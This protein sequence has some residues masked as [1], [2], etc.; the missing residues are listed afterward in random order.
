VTS[1]LLGPGDE[2]TWEA[3]HFGVR[4][5]LTARITRFEPP[6]LFEDEMVRGAFRSFTHTHEFRPVEGG[7]LMVDTF[8]YASPLGPLGVLA[9]KLFIERHMRRFLTERAASLKR[10]A[11]AG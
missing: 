6:H 3:V 9:D 1:G 5:R 8:R 10:L 2:V 4:Q 11:E 7:T